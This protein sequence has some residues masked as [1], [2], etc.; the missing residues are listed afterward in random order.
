VSRIVVT[1]LG[2]MSALGNSSLENRNSLLKS[3]C[4]LS[5]LELFK[6]KYSGLLRFGEIKITNQQ[7]KELHGI[8]DK[9]V[10][11]TSLLAVQAMDEALKDSRLNQS[12]ISSYDT[13]LVVGNTV[14]GMC[15]TDELYHD[16]NSREG[17][18]P[19]ISSYD[20][21]SITLYLQDK[22]GIKGVC[23][24]INTAC[25]SS[26]NAIMYG[27]R[28]IKNNYVK[29][30]VVGGVDSL[31]KFTI[32]GFN[33][34]G[35]LSPRNCSPF[36]KDRDGLNLGEG[37]GFIVLEKEEDVVGRKMY[38]ALSGYCNANDSFHPSTI[39]E[40]AEGPYRAMK[41]A[42]DLAGLS[43]DKIG[44]INTHGTGTVNNDETE[45]K[46]MI[47]VF[48]TVPPFAS[49]KSKIGHTLGASAAI[50]AVFSVMA[51]SNQ[52]IYSSL[53]FN[54]AIE[55][56]GLSPVTECKNYSYENIMSNSFGFGG[57]CS[58]LIF[59]KI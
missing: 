8:T 56:T 5:S 39:S 3:V 23:N 37:S 41:G 21:G 4:G 44:Y 7:L 2:V 38:A 48:G 32:N 45:G 9:G 46:G 34:L 28:L 36:D 42:L 29:R 24:T 20:C 35:I 55:S 15:L 13:A 25:S 57:N 14:G 19:Y 53:N 47:R 27:A 17:G 43:A 58:S 6:T 49:S 1:G 59:S 10:T 52:E 33:S 40:T 12:Q 11:R 30:A 18:S 31:A 22:Y 51:L 54:T 26:A 50:E 16:A